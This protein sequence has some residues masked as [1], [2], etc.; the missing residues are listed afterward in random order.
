MGMKPADAFRYLI[1]QIADEFNVHMPGDTD[2]F[3]P[4]ADRTADR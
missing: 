2:G 3:R 1:V 4:E